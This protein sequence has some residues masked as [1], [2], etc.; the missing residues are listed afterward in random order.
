MFSLWSKQQPFP[1]YLD[2]QKVTSCILFLSAVVL[3]T[4]PNPP[5]C[6]DS[7]YLLGDMCFSLHG[8]GE[9][10]QLDWYDAESRCQQE[11]I[12]IGGSQGHLA[13]IKFDGVNCKYK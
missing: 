5:G 4:T 11:A 12:D 6:P 1:G 2:S 13:N 7:W 10:Q 8:Y 3:A 9:N